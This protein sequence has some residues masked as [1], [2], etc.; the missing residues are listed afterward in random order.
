MKKR[1]YASET[2]GYNYRMTEFEAAIGRAQLKHIDEANAVRQQH[3]EYLTKQLSKFPGINP[4]KVEPGSTHVYYVYPF[5]YDE[6]ETGI[7]RK[8]SDAGVSKDKLERLSRLAFQDSCHHN[9]PRPVT[10]DDF[11]KIFSEAF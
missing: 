10:E 11:V 7:P 9:N 8:L 5:T 2:L 3:A 1:S 4:P 6:E